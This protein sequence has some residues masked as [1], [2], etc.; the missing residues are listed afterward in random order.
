MT[1]A[2][3]GVSGLFVVLAAIVVLAWAQGLRSSAM[4]EN[5]PVRRAVI[6]SERW[7]I[8]IGVLGLACAV[9]AMVR[10]PVPAAKAAERAVVTPS[11]QLEM[12]RVECGVIGG[13]LGKVIV[14][15]LIPITGLSGLYKPL[16]AR[17]DD[18]QLR[19][20]YT[21]DIDDGRESVVVT[22]GLAYDIAGTPKGC[23]EAHRASP[24]CFDYRPIRDVKRV[25]LF[26]RKCSENGAVCNDELL[27]ETEVGDGFAENENKA[28]P[29]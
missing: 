4:R 6:L 18:G 14:A 13:C 19:V 2:L 25:Q 29:E 10:V 16:A 15:N 3:L 22:G 17:I 21:G 11:Y 26:G 20:G 27:A 1:D 7:A 9:Y 12:I 8:A 24:R 5:V 28:G 23:P